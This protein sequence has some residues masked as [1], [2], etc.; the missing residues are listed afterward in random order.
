MHVLEQSLNGEP[1]LPQGFPAGWAVPFA[2]QIAAIASNRVPT[3]LSGQLGGWDLGQG[4]DHLHKI[5][6][7]ALARQPHVTRLESGPMEYSQQQAR[8]LSFLYRCFTSSDSSHNTL[9][10]EFS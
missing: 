5:R 10:G 4:S 3:L 1:T 9:L 2:C 8:D 7:Q 6:R